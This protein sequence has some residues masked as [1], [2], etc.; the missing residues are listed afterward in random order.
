ML[1]L[2]EAQTLLG[3]YIIPLFSMDYWEPP[4]RC[5]TAVRTHPV[6][7]NGQPPKVPSSNPSA[8]S[9]HNNNFDFV[10]NVLQAF[11]YTFPTRSCTGP[12]HSS[13][14]SDYAPQSS[15][16]LIIALPS[17]TSPCRID[18]TD[19]LLPARAT[20]MET[21]DAPTMIIDPATKMATEATD[22][23]RRP[24]PSSRDHRPVFDRCPLDHGYHKFKLKHRCL[25]LTPRD[26]SPKL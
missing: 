10:I 16:F 26:K 13:V 14:P 15:P 5:W 3:T 24:L 19:L 22:M 9:F 7:R 17:P 25:R 18:T 11:A 1:L 8:S 12:I 23:P 20:V 4:V 21:S 6:R 2:N